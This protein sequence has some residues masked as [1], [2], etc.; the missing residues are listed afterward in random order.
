MGSKVVKETVQ[1]I[2]VDRGKKKLKNERIKSERK[3]EDINNYLAGPR[4]HR[5][6]N[7]GQLFHPLCDP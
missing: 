1:R 7:G 3:S 4:G 6:A 5:E 2:G